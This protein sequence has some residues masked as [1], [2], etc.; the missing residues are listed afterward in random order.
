MVRIN[1]ELVGEPT[2]T[3]SEALKAEGKWTGETA[4]PEVGGQPNNEPLVV[5]GDYVPE[6]TGSKP[7]AK[8]K[9][10]SKAS[11]SK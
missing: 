4:Y 8:A 1:K 9:S 7:A 2:V 6:K 5:R 11:K 3:L 10:T